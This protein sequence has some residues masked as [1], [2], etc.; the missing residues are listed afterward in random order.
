MTD[1]RLRFLLIQNWTKRMDLSLRHWIP[2]D[3]ADM[4]RHGMLE[5]ACVICV[6]MTKAMF[7]P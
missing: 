7:I 4:R 3:F 1:A 6:N 2:V 5:I